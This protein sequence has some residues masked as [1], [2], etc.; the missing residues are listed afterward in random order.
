[1]KSPEKSNYLP[2]GASICMAIDKVHNLNFLR[3]KKYVLC[4][5][6][7]ESQFTTKKKKRYNMPF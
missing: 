7:L 3:Q 5:G 6:C 4:S 2:F 1:M